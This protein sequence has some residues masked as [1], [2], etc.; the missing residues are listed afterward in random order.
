VR[1]RYSKAQ[2]LDSAKVSSTLRYDRDGNFFGVESGEDLQDDE[3]F[4]RI[5]WW[6]IVMHSPVQD[7]DITLGGN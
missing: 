5:K 3:T 1:G 2:N 6:M 4:L 7:A